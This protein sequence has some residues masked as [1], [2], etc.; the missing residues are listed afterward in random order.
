MTC[1]DCQLACYD[2]LDQSLSAKDEREVLAHV[3]QCPACRAF[4]EAEGGRM[5]TWPRLLSV[6][7][8]RA[9]MADDVAERVAHVLEVSRGRA[10]RQRVGTLFRLPSHWYALAASLLALAS[11]VSAAVL[12]GGHISGERLALGAEAVQVDELPAVRLVSQKKAQGAEI[13]TALPGALAL[14]SGECVVRLST[15]VELTVLGPA[16]LT[17]QTGMQVSLEQGRLL[18]RVPHW[19]TGFTVLTR[20]LEIYDL[21]TVFGVSADDEG[22]E[23]FVFKGNIQVNEAGEWGP[24]SHTSGAGVGICAAG[25]GVRA[26]AGEPPV[27]FDMDGLDVERLFAPFKGCGLSPCFSIDKLD[28]CRKQ[29]AR[30][31][32]RCPRK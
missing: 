16:K 32:N 24:G 18:A 26:R 9:V 2:L 13:P 29:R 11:M 3:E 20:E 28:K 31:K 17:V 30:S 1:E 8:R 10:M 7:T 15:G 27:P 12:L 14:A 6:A 22:S 23:T 4:L 21:G 25:E 19:A 5:R